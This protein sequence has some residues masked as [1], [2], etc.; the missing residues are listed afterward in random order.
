MPD[1]RFSPKLYRFLLRFYPTGFHDDYAGLLDH[2]FRDALA[3]SS[4]ILALARLWI[5]L[6]ADLAV[7][8]RTYGSL[9]R[10]QSVLGPRIGTFLRSGHS[11]E[12]GNSKFPFQDRIRGPRTGTGS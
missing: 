7:S 8:I 10:R 3:E 5:R 12:R 11:T 1:A 2:E 9:L 6:L 4:D